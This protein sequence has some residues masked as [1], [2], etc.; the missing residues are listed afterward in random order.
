MA[1]AA[2]E[3]AIVPMHVDEYDSALAERLR[4]QVE[5][6]PE[7]TPSASGARSDDS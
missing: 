4:R 2:G 6:I 5:L 3:I 1:V 7:W